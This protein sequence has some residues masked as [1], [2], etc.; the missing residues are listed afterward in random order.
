MLFMYFANMLRSFLHSKYGM[1][2][3]FKKHFYVRKD[4]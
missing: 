3:L 4:N 1:S 2:L